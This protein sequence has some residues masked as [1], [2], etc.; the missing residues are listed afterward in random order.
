MTQA[1]EPYLRADLGDLDAI[2]YTAER[3][4]A[5]S[6]LYPAYTVAVPR[7]I[8][9]VPIAIPVADGDPALVELLNTWLTVKKE[10]RTIRRL[11]DYWVLG[12]E[13]KPREKRWSVIRDVLGWVE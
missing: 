6:L 4:S 1:V 10:D 12:R 7:P 11:Y 8:V 3:G 9:R 13:E 5:W 2:L